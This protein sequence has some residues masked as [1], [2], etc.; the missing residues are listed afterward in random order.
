MS[1][2]VIAFGANGKRVCD[3]LLVITD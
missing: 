2:K 3:F 1:F